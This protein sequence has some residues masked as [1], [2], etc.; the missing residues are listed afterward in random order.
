MDYNQQS[1]NVF[2]KHAH[3]YEKQFMG[4]S[5][6]DDS[7][8]SLLL[9]LPE[10]ATVLELGCGPG[11]IS[12]YLLKKSPSLR[13]LATDAAPEMIKLA[14][15][16]LPNAVCKVLL[17]KDI[18]KLNTPFDAVI[19]GF[20]FPYFTE[21]DAKQLLSE[22][23][24]LTKPNG[25]LYCSFIEGDYAKSGPQISSDGNDTAFVHY[26][27]EKQFEQMLAASNFTVQNRYRIAW[28]KADTTLENHLI[29]I[30]QHNSL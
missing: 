10:N 23:S 3:R 30:A 9:C 28:Q 13:V 11:M 29:L 22:I 4:L 19:C 24:K 12:N 7:Y 2:E 17:T 14:E 18:A 27:A 6:Y 16:N 5:L 20:L 15:K 25:Y 21:H 26:Y 1:I 8:D